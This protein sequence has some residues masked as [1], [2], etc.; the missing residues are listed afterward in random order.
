MQLTRER[1]TANRPDWD[2][3]IDLVT[4]A[5][6]EGRAVLGDDPALDLGGTPLP[7]LLVEPTETLMAT[8]PGTGRTIELQV[9]LIVMRGF[10]R[11]PTGAPAPART[12]DW[13]LHSAPDGLELVDGNAVW[14]QVAA[15]PDAAWRSAAAAGGQV[16]VLYGALLGVHTPRGVPHDQYGPEQRAAELRAGRSLGLVAAAT[17]AWRS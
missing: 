14:T 3:I 7:V 12:P 9:E 1:A 5:R 8:D 13:S 2:H 15:C 10:S 16:L 11:F 17:V 6:H 4:D